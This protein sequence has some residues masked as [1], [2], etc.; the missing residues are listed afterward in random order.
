[1]LNINN[2]KGGIM[3]KIAMVCLVALSVLALSGCNKSTE[4]ASSRFDLPEGM[5]DCEIYRMKSNSGTVIY[6]IRCPLSTTT[7]MTTGKHQTQVS[8]TETENKV[9]TQPKEKIVVNGK[10]FIEE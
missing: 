10:H 3:K 1:M 4:D 2:Y 8:V 5:K 9:Q 6:A 7:T